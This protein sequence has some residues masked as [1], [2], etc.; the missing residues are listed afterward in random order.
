MLITAVA[1]V[2]AIAP[3]RA[4]WKP[5]YAQA[6]PEVRAWYGSAELTPAAAARLG[7]KRCCDESEVVKTRFR[8]DRSSG[9]DEW[10]YLK[11]GKF[12]RIPLDI[13]HWGESAPGG[14]PTLFVL[15]D[16]WADAFHRP[17]GTPTCFYPGEGGL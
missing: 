4:E 10:Y 6:S 2:V 1:A 11:N 12:E 9:Q 5:Q 17:H 15:S 16:H 8:V 3:A 14:K 13:I 7:F